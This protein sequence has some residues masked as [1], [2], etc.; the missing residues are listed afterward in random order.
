MHPPFAY[1]SNSFVYMHP[2]LFPS[3]W[4]ITNTVRTDQWLVGTRAQLDWGKEKLLS[5]RIGAY[6]L[7]LSLPWNSF[8][9][10]SFHFEQRVPWLRDINLGL[11]NSLPLARWI[12]SLAT[13]DFGIFLTG[14]LQSNSAQ[15]VDY[16]S[17]TVWDLAYLLVPETCDQ[18]WLV[19]GYL[20]PAIDIGSGAG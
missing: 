6:Y 17:L 3:G 18:Q 20:R 1:V 10:T 5:L 15:S 11:G 9:L 13:L 4:D 2:Y 19:L 7:F 8:I 14:I 12:R 16:T